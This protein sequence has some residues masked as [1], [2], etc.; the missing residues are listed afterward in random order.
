MQGLHSKSQSLLALA[1][2]RG[3]RINRVETSI[4]QRRQQSRRWQATNP[5]YGESQISQCHISS[6]L[7]PT[8]AALH[9]VLADAIAL[10]HPDVSFKL[11]FALLSCL[12]S[13]R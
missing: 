5:M 10:E 11:A 7:Q 13:C 6:E 1:S 2:L 9:R 12:R 8:A 4:I 3:A